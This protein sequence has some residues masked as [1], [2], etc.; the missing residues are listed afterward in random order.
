MKNVLITG[1]AGFIGSNYAHMLEKTRSDLNIII[2]DALTYAGNYHNLENLKKIKFVKGNIEDFNL[3]DSLFEQYQI[4]T[5]INFAAESHVDR[6]ITNPSIFV[7]TNVVGTQTLLEVCK[8]RWLSTPQANTN[9]FLE[10]STDE[11]YGTLGE[12]GKFTENTNLLPNSPYSASKASADLLVRAYNKTY[13]L[14]T[15]ITRCSNNYGPHQFPEKLIPKAI[16]LAQT[17]KKIPIYGNGKQ[18]RDW[19]Y[20]LDH[21]EAI[22]AVLEKGKLGEVYNVGANN[23]HT[24]LEIVSKILSEL[25]ISESRI[26]HVTDRPGH[27]TRYAIDNTKIHDEIKWSPKYS[28]EKALKMTI[29]WYLDNEKWLEDINTGEYQNS[30]TGE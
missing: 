10:I 27:D 6:S 23:E 7:N 1:A 14:P 16:T 17:G 29:N 18:I 26:E 25:S 8:K 24:N 19:I 22:N 5:V 11:V 30:Y 2:L 12:F 28:F 13:G 15:L 9:K 3:V 20:V 4:D 21:C